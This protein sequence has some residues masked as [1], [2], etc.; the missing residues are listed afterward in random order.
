MIQRIQSLFLA[1]V[2]GFSIMLFFVP[3]SQKSTVDAASGETIE[4]V[5]ALVPSNASSVEDSQIV[6]VNYFLLVLNLIILAAATFTIFQYNNRPAQLRLCALTGLFA[7]FFLGLVFYFSDSIQG[8]GKPHYITGTYLV[9][10]QVFLILAARRF[11]RKDE[12]LVRA[13]QRI[14]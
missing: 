5:L 2:V 3:F 7:A 14:R 4:R 9:A 1:A 6:E 11:I 13:S 10:V 12:Q 8:E